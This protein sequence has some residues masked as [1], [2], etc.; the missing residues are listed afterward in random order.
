M[1]KRAAEQEVK[2]LRKQASRAQRAQRINVAPALMSGSMSPKEAALEVDTCCFGRQGSE[3][4]REP[5]SEL[6]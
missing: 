6:G 5:G 4:V 2:A 3:C 1:R